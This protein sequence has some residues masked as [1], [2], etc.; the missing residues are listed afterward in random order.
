MWP[1]EPKELPTPGLGGKSSAYFLAVRNS[2]FG[3]IF[4]GETERRL[5]K[6]YNF[7]P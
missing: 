4:V 6:N 1:A 2:E 7:A 3:H 5:P